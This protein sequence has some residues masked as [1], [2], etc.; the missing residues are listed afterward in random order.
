MLRRCV[1]ADSFSITSQSRGKGDIEVR[2]MRRAV[3]KVACM[4]LNLRMS[5]GI[6]GF[7]H[8]TAPVPQQ[9]SRVAT[10]HPRIGAA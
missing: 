5:V 1:E 10:L 9:G 6:R 3:V 4:P 7:R 8:S 2:T